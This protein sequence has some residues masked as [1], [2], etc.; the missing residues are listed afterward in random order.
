MK[1]HV[2]EKKEKDRRNL[3]SHIKI[4]ADRVDG[5]LEPLSKLAEGKS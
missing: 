1:S 2:A 3:F 4:E 5:G